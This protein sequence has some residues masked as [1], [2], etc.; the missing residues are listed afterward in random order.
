MYHDVYTRSESEKRCMSEPSVYSQTSPSSNLSNTKYVRIGVASSLGALWELSGSS[1]Q[2][3]VSSATVVIPP[4][5]P[6]LV[7]LSMLLG[8]P[9]EAGKH[10]GL[11]VVGWQGVGFAQTAQS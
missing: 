6:Q 11:H 4:P 3:R 5:P 1:S 7:L 2:L 10:L 8:V 9:P